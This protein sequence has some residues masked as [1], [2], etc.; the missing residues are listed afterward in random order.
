LRD[1]AR[2][3]IP[4]TEKVDFFEK[5]TLFTPKTQISEMLRTFR[6]KFSK[7]VFGAGKFCAPLKTKPKSTFLGSDFSAQKTSATRKTFSAKVK[8]ISSKM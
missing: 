4:G 7:S 8:I 5:I 3:G 6:K 1:G 2:N